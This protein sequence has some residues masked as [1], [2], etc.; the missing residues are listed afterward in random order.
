MGDSAPLVAAIQL[1]T[2]AS[3]VN[4]FNLSLGLSPSYYLALGSAVDFGNKCLDGHRQCHML[5]AV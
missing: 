3:I 2:A 5:S 1:P 4:L